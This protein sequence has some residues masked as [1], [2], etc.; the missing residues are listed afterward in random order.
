MSVIFF[1]KIIF[2][3]FNFAS[4]HT[5]L[6]FPELSKHGK[7]MPSLSFFQ[8]GRGGSLGSENVRLSMFIIVN[9]KRFMSHSPHARNKYLILTE[10]T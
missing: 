5:H 6:H 8:G 1:F 9:H 3:K 7:K 2:K 4:I 10:N